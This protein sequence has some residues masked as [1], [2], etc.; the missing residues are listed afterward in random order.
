MMSLRI[1]VGCGI[2]I[3]FKKNVNNGVEA[4]LLSKVFDSMYCDFLGN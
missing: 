2:F 4:K 3:L 1:F